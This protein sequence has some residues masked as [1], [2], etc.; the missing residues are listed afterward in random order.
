MTYERKIKYTTISISV[1]LTEKIKEYLKKEPYQISV[2]EFV[3]TAIRE[4]FERE[5]Q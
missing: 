1:P 3:R 4:K 2:G 5:K